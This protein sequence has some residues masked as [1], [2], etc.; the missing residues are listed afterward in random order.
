MEAR[1]WKE[2]DRKLGRK[3]R[4]FRRKQLENRAWNRRVERDPLRVPSLTEK[5]GRGEGE[6]RTK[7]KRKVK[8]SVLGGRM[9]KGKGLQSDR[10]EKIG[11]TSWSCF[12]ITWRGGEGEAKL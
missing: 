8:K 12:F 6:E 9:E 5:E 1:N 10:G 3:G 11:V 4:N 2:E 7:K